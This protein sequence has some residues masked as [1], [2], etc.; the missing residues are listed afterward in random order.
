MTYTDLAN[1]S[2]DQLSQTTEHGAMAPDTDELD[3][4]LSVTSGCKAGATPLQSN[5]GRWGFGLAKHLH[6]E[7]RISFKEANVAE[8]AAPAVASVMC[9]EQLV[10]IEKGAAE[11]IRQALCKDCGKD[12]EPR[13][14]DGKPIAA[15]WDV[16]IV[17]PEI[18]NAAGM[19]AY[20]SGNLCTPCLSKRLGRELQE[21]DYLARVVTGPDGSLMTKTTRANAF[22]VIAL[23]VAYREKRERA[24][25]LVA[26]KRLQKR[27]RKKHA[28][29]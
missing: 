19:D 15:E 25:K 24:A 3:R 29:R 28:K 22:R 8:L 27:L 14:E 23:N 9:E 13:S 6:K 21:S 2:V 1:F 12:T 5:S 11:C 17:R 4:L 18:W 10:S 16:Y 26:R 7:R 20:D